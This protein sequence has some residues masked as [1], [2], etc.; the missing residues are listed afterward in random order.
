[1]AELGTTDTVIYTVAFSPTKS[2]F[3]RDLRYGP[4]G[5]PKSE[6][7]PGDSAHASRTKV[8]EAQVGSEPVEELHYVDHPPSFSFPPLL[9]L[10]V[11]GLR[12]NAASEITK[13]SG[14]EY[15]SFVT[16]KGLEQAL[17]HIANQIHNYYLLSF[18]PEGFEKLGLHSITVRVAGQADAVI[19]TR[20]S[21]WSGIR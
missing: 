20:R 18:R 7:P 12:Q 8:N 11:N 1:M 5:P 14:G 19:Q 10:A 3:L 4:N 2:Q 16:Q 13:L 9:M 17:N 15:L 6:P 21:Y